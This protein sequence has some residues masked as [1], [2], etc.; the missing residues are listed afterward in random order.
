MLATWNVKG[1]NATEK[2]RD[3]TNFV[4]KNNLGFVGLI[5]TK[6]K[7]EKCFGTG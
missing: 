7:K 5:K 4:Y 6:L 1:M 3:V 2:Q